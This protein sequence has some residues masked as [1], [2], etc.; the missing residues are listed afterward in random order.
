MTPLF[1]L[2][3]TA[4]LLTAAACNEPQPGGRFRVEFAWADGP[5]AAEQTLYAYSAV[6]ALRDGKEPQTL[7]TAGP[8]AYEPGIELG[9]RDVPLG[10]ALRV[11]VELRASRD[12][13]EAPLYYGISE[14]FAIDPGDDLVVPIRIELR[15]APG[16]SDAQLAIIA[17]GEPGYTN[18]AD[19][20][21][22]VSSAGAVA[23]LLSNRAGLPADATERVELDADATQQELDWNLD[24]GL[25]EP[26]RDEDSCERRVFARLLDAEG[27]ASAIFDA[28]TILD[29]RAPSVASDPPIERTLSAAQDNPLARPELM[30]YLQRVRPGTRVRLAFTLSEAV[31]AAPVVSARSQASDAV[32]EWKAKSSEGGTSFVYELEYAAGLA[33]DGGE[34]TF[35]V[36]ISAHD[37]AGNQ[38][39]I[40]LDAEHGFSADTDAPEA[41]RGLV[42]ERAPWG[43]G[44]AGAAQLGVRA[45]AKA[46]EPEAVLEILDG[47]TASARSLGAGLADASGGMAWLEL[48][49]PD[50]P[51]AYARAIDAAGNASEVTAISDVAWSASFADVGRGNPHR[52]E[53]RSWFLGTLEQRDAR[54]AQ[55]VALTKADGDQLAARGGGRFSRAETP[56][57]ASIW[58]SPLGVFDRV[59]GR[60][61]GYGQRAPCPVTG[62]SCDATWSW[63]GQRLDV[64]AASTR[65][66][67]PVVWHGGRGRALILD[68]TADDCPD[69]PGA[70][71]SHTVYWDGA[72][73][74]ERVSA[75]EAT[76]PRNVGMDALLVYDERRDRV[77]MFGG[78]GEPEEKACTFEVCGDTWQWDGARWT[79]LA[80]VSGTPSPRAGPAGTYDPRLGLTILFGGTNRPETDD[81]G[82]EEW[83]N[84]WRDLD[85]TWTFDG[86][87]WTQQRAPQ[88]AP[89]Q[90]QGRSAAVMT[91]S[92]RLG[93]AVMYGGTRHSGGCDGASTPEC[94]GLWSWAGTHWERIEELGPRPAGR[95][96]LSFV[97]GPFGELL[98]LGGRRDSNAAGDCPESDF[99]GFMCTGLWAF[100]FASDDSG[101]ALLR[102]RWRN[103]ADE[104]VMREASTLPVSD[105]HPVTDRA[106]GWDQRSETLRMV[107][108][109]AGDRWESRVW[110]GHPELM[111]QD[112][113]QAAFLA[114]L[115]TRVW[116]WTGNGFA[117]IAPDAAHSP[118][119]GHALVWSAALN[120]PLLLGGRT[121]TACASG[122]GLCCDAAS[123][124]MCETSWLLDAQQRLAAGPSLRG[125]PGARAAAG[126]ASIGGDVLLFGGYRYAADGTASTLGETWRF[127]NSGWSRVESAEEPSPRF[128]P[129]F[130]YDPSSDRALLFG[131][132]DNA[133][134]AACG[135]ALA[136]T[137]VFHAGAWQALSPEHAPSARRGA[138]LAFAP[139]RNALV[140]YGGASPGSCDGPVDACSDVWEWQGDDWR[141]V[142]LTD[143]EGDGDPGPHVGHVMATDLARGEIVLHGG[144]FPSSTPGVSPENSWVWHPGAAARPAQVASFDLTSASAP[145]GAS[146]RAL[147]LIW[148]GSAQSSAGSEVELL[149]WCRGRFVPA[150]EL[151]F[152]RDS[153]GW[154]NTRP[155][156]LALLRYA[157]AERETLTLALIPKGPNG[158]TPGY[159]SLATDQLALRVSYRLP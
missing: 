102:G 40:Q 49:P 115:Q 37:R 87:R 29:T 43:N 155:D 141:A 156:A 21:L 77:V 81:P 70:W 55:G 3:L 137:H 65:P 158:T 121:Q 39:T 23:V 14:R 82:T 47:P 36:Q 44:G 113:A 139:G 45:A 62:M 149:A 106:L 128:A 152:E 98:V 144:G 26:C 5:P 13:N 154:T 140:L 126:V 69:G 8:E 15:A 93:R 38:R 150:A 138:A 31:R 2:L 1:R 107:T 30:R 118:R 96:E 51:R 33:A 151:G 147:S 130:A 27:Y 20:R 135:A 63:N 41:P 56:E 99:G 73:T 136:D 125:G 7:S 104:V 6:Q 50:L 105:A 86:E 72:K 145:S 90:P 24:D 48:A 119:Y 124:A 143:P 4:A 83:L 46:V 16:K 57:H 79:E 66:L 122:S 153:E 108:G 97:E 10:R 89:P 111:C 95:T 134:N 123:G 142:E 42:Y 116:T 34:E 112:P 100:E 148:H 9:F 129:A 146:V 94:S 18:T 74:F 114:T 71:C 22:R 54:I 127:G 103:Y 60:A 92:S 80:A 131:G 52:F 35:L 67:G 133:V 110:D 109:D 25:P 53:S 120:A 117:P 101:A 32:L 76:I 59:H 75:P 84:S 64:Q 28:R 91:Y 68:G 159:A 12:L 58:F 19:V 17:T 78:Y 61:V 132:E 11:I 88:G 85:D 157:Q